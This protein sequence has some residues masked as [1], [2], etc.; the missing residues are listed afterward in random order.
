MSIIADHVLSQCHIG[1]ELVCGNQV[2]AKIIRKN[3]HLIE[4]RDIHGKH[5]SINLERLCNVEY[6]TFL[7][8]LSSA[9]ARFHPDS[10]SEISTQQVLA[11][12]KVGDE[13]RDFSG[14]LAT[15]VEIEPYTDQGRSLTFKDVNE[16]RH[17]VFLDLIPNDLGFNAYLQQFRLN[18][19]S[20]DGPVPEPILL[21]YFKHE[22]IPKMLAQMEYDN[23]RWGD[24]WLME[25]RVGQ[26]NYINKRLDEYFN[27]F[28]QFGKNVPWL[29]VIG[30]A[31]IAQARED[32]PEWLL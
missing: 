31:I 13:L 3:E 1:S 2:I 30:H 17:Q 14:F 23:D 24:T 8:D 4:I 10:A 26:E 16:N 15:L 7:K 12:M 6:R 22:F 20:A 5:W 25:P 21:H 28:E 9:I 19:E 11:S 27:F 29:K 32:H 18:V